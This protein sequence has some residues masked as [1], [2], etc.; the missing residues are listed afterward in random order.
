MVL[1]TDDQIYTFPCPLCGH[2]IS[3]K[4]G[5]IR[6]S[7]DFLCP[8]CHSSLTRTKACLLKVV[9]RLNLVWGTNP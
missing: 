3:L 4:I 9:D 8:R 2:T 5:D 6:A 7:V 1:T